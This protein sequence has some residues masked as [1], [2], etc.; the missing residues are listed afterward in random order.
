[1]YVITCDPGPVVCFDG[2]P[3][4]HSVGGSGFVFRTGTKTVEVAV[5]EKTSHYTKVTSVIPCERGIHM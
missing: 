5:F 3:D 2:C 1:M 4:A